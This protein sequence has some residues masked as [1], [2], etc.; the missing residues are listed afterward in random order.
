VSAEGKA[1]IQRCLARKQQ[2]RPDVPAAA[3]DA[4][5]TYAKATPE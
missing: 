4:Y 2:D 5:M 1:F 3:A